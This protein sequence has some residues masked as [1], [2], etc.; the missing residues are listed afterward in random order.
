[1]LGKNFIAKYVDLK[2]PVVSINI[3]NTPVPNTLIDLGETI[4]IMTKETRENI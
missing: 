4:N 2:I 1:M 3:N